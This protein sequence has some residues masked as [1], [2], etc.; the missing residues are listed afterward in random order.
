MSLHQQNSSQGY[1]QQAFNVS[2]RSRA[3]TLLELLTE[4]NANIKE[5]INPQ[6][7]AQEKSLQSQLDATEKQR[8]DINNNPQSTTKQKT[9]I[10]QRHETLLE[11]YQNLQDEI[12]QKSPKYAA[13][14]YPQPLTLEQVQQ[15]ILDDNTTLLQYSLGAEKSYLWVVTKEGMT[16]YQLPSQE[17]NSNSFAQAEP[18]LSQ[19]ILAPAQDKLTVDGGHS[20][21]LAFKAR[22]R[23][24]KKRLLIVADGVLQYIPFSA[25][26][27]SVNQQPLINQYEITNLPSSSSLAT[28]RHEIQ[29]RKSAPKTLAILANPVFS[30]DNERVENRKTNLSQQ[31]SDLDLLALNRSVRSL[32]EDKLVVLKM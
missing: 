31:P 30:Q 18:L 24:T 19:V 1:D 4:A 27:L 3:R 6:L 14:K 22:E 23:V 26:S 11:Q 12:R 32:E 20:Q 13:L 21:A 15:Q 10:E 28:I 9:A 5:E 25:L 17:G 7:L 16:S 8:L 29:T 2:E